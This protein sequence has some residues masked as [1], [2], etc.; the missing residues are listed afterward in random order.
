MFELQYAATVTNC[1]RQKHKLANCHYK[2]MRTLQVFARWPLFVFQ[3][4]STL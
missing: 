1:Y 4:W 2:I 3:F